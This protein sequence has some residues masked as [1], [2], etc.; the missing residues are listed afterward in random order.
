VVHFKEQMAYLP[1]FQNKAIF[2]NLSTLEMI[3][4]ARK[5]PEIE[6]ITNATFNKHLTGLSA[7][8]KFAKINR[9]MKGEDPTIGLSMS[10]D[11]SVERLSYDDDDIKNIFSHKIYKET[12]DKWNSKQWLPIFALYHGMRME[13][14]GQL[15]VQDIKTVKDVLYIRISPYDDA[16]TEC[17]SVKN[18][19]ERD[20]PIH[21]RL[22]ELGFLEYLNSK[23]NQ[24]LLF[25][26]LKQLPDKLKPELSK[27]THYFSK[28]YGVQREGFGVQNSRK[29]FHSFRHAFKDASRRYISDEEIRDRLTGHKNNSVGR[30]YGDGHAMLAL[31]EAIDKIT[32]ETFPL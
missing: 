13:E 25:P 16:G 29:T 27:K 4:M 8:I 19:T 18:G 20:I 14:I 11:D 30:S 17:K 10:T 1:T 24:R 15:L 6:T 31:K 28:W 7:I 32:Y 21:K 23:K 22:I 3:N 9:K 26:D 2:K 12:I 5:D